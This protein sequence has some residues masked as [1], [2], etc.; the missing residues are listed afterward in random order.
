MPEPVVQSWRCEVCRKTFGSKRGAS[1]CEKRHEE[2]REDE[3]RFRDVQRTIRVDDSWIILM[4]ARDA[5]K[6]AM[7]CVL[8]VGDRPTSDL[9]EAR[10]FQGIGEVREWEEQQAEKLHNQRHGG[11]L[12]TPAPLWGAGV[13]PLPWGAETAGSGGARQSEGKNP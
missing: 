1:L 4:T 5:T 12:C 9:N 3:R 6:N 8:S 13:P 2:Q 7:I 10:V 11:W